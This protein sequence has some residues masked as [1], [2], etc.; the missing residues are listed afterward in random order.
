M[1]VGVREAALRLGFTQ[2]YVRDLLYEGKLPGARKEG[3]EWRIPVT[4]V[5]RR[6]RQ[7]QG[8]PIES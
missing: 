1:T 6:L 3:R 2:K 4:V 7:P 5:E 8:E